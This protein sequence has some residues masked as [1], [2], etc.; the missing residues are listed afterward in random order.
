MLMYI[1]QRIIAAIFFASVVLCNASCKKFVQITPP[2]TQI[3]T[4]SV[5]NDNNA[6]TAAL[7]AIYSRM[8]SES[9]NMAQCTGLLGDELQS[10]SSSNFILPYYQNA[11]LATTTPIPGPWGTA[12]SYIYQANAVIEGLQNNE[13]V[14]GA[15]EKQL[16]GEAKFLRAFWNFYLVNCYGDI[17]LILSTDYTINATISRSS[18]D[19]VYQQIINDLKDASDLLNSNYVDESDITSTSERIRPNKGAA[20]ALLARVYLYI[21]DYAAAENEANAVL[22]NS[23]YQLVQDINE[24]FLINSTEAIW[25]LG[26]PS[27]STYSTV[28]GYNFIL[29]TAP[30]SVAPALTATISP[31]LLNSFE[32]NDQR[33][34]KWIGAIT[35]TS[36]DTTYYFPYKYKSNGL[37]VTEYTMML[38]LAE[39]YLIHAEA[40]VRQNKNLGQAVADIDTIRRRAGLGNYTGPLVT[41]SLLTAILHERQ[42][43]LFCE[44]GHRWFD[45]IRTG[46]INAVMSVVNQQKGGLGWRPEWALFPIPQSER[47]RDFN[48]S[49]N[50]GYD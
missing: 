26:V 18:K 3:V 35:T 39:Q 32:W 11:L 43:E 19:K 25:Q 31:D 24:V 16:T 20:A 45:L 30:S 4:S 7:T 36:P 37:P 13:G 5:F 47:N 41:D 15:V 27:P 10:S 49:Q 29:T 21:G 12:F 44:W 46:N 33:R 48:L 28:D 42:V 34:I 22:T 17:P 50:P 9:W 1:S 8:Q 23:Q 38:R 6:A 40:L 14:S 2:S